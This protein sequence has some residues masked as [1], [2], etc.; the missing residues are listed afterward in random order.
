MAHIVTCVYC[1]NRFDRDK[2]PFV[3]VS[4]RRYAHQACSMTDDQ[5]KAKEVKDKEELDEYIKQLFKTTYVDARIQKQ[6][7]Q[8]VE[9]YNFTYSGIKKALIYFFEIK[10]NSIN[11]NNGGIGIVPYVYQNAYNYYLALWQAQQKN[12]D[13]VLQDYVPNIKEIVIPPP[14]RNVKKRPLFTFLDEEEE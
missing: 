9:E 8:Y 7:K 6:I 1:K 13:K 10:G 12:S 3:T 2:Q 14:Q 4:T 5:K 11:K